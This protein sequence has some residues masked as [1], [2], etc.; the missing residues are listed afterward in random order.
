MKKELLKHLLDIAY[1]TAQLPVE[2]E[3]INTIYDRFDTELKK[4]TMSNDGKVLGGSYFICDMRKGKEFLDY[5]LSAFDSI[6]DEITVSIDKPNQSELLYLIKE[7]NDRELTVTN[8]T[9]GGLSTT[10]TFETNY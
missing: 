9:V 10:I 8:V 5:A 1:P 4:I 6:A 7:L 3:K 2:K